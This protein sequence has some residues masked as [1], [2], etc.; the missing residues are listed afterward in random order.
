MY[1]HIFVMQTTFSIF[2]FVTCHFETN[3]VIVPDS[4]IPL[5]CTDLYESFFAKS[6]QMNSAIRFKMKD[7]G[8]LTVIIGISKFQFSTTATTSSNRGKFSYQIYKVERFLTVI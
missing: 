7:F 8:N 4:L 6:S 2:M 1:N 3:N 5:V